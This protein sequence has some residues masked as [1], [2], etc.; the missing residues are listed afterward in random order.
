MKA[1]FARVWVRR[2]QAM[3][4]YAVIAAA[5]IV[6]AYVTFQ[7]VGTGVNTAMTTVLGAL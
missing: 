6:A 2:G 3:P 7:A 5:I 4:E 1:S